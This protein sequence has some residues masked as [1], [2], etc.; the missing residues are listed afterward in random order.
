MASPSSRRSSSS[1]ARTPSRS[2]RSTPIQ[3]WHEPTPPGD[4]AATAWIP[5]NLLNEGTVDIE[6][7]ICSLGFPKLE[8]HAAIY[9]AVSVEVLDP[10]EG[11]SARGAFSGQWR[12]VVRP[13]LEWSLERR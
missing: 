12:G 10:G 6:V 7:A 3:R 8:H 1:T 11:D 4:Y 5:G 2:T 9:E 13:L